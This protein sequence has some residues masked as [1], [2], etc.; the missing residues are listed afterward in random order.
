MAETSIGR[1]EFALSG[2]PRSFERRSSISAPPSRL[3]TGVVGLVAEDDTGVARFRGT[4]TH[5]GKWQGVAPTGRSMQLAPT[6][7]GAMPD[8][9]AARRVS[10]VRCPRTASLTEQLLSREVVS[11][12]GQPPL[13]DHG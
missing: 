10:V 8:T 12:A 11:R 4:G 2:L 9:K 6:T 13:L 3:A 7:S 5:S 1:I